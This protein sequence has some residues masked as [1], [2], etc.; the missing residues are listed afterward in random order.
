MAYKFGHEWQRERER[1]ATIEQA[2][3]PW[4]IRTIE[5]TSPVHTGM[6]RSS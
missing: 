4:S 3:D 5:A 6:N 1:F 2:Y